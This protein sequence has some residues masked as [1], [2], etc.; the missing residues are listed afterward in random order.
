MKLVGL[1]VGAV[2]VTGACGDGGDPV[3]SADS[4]TAEACRGLVDI[5]LA[6]LDHASPTYLDDLEGFADRWEALAEVLGDDA[7]VAAAKSTAAQIREAVADGSVDGLYSPEAA[8]TE[9]QVDAWAA[10]ACAFPV[11]EVSIDDSALEVGSV[12]AGPVVFHVRNEGTVGHQLTVNRIRDD[13]DES[14]EEVLAS[15]GFD[16][17]MAKIDVVTSGAVVPAGEEAFLV[18]DLR[19]GRYLL[20]DPSTE[21]GEGP[22]FLDGVWASTVV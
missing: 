5:R 9:G 10:G 13:V 19:A 2:I 6:Q 15:P 14:A 11:I 22:A 1:A 21:G 3:A 7:A 12:P 8:A 20:V 17:L 16:A 4:G 18:S